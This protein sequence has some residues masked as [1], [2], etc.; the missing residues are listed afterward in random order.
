MSFGVLARESCLFPVL[1]CVCLLVEEFW[2]LKFSFD[3]RFVDLV[4]LESF[5]FALCR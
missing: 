4:A 1:E 3:L 5:L 2:T